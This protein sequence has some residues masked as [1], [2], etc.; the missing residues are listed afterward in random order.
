MFI[1]SALLYRIS[2]DIDVQY[3]ECFIWNLYCCYSLLL[4]ILCVPIQGVSY[5]ANRMHSRSS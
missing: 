5:A 4:Y 1:V 2:D 3:I